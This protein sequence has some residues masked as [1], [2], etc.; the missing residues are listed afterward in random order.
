[1]FLTMPGYNNLWIAWN[2]QYIKLFNVRS[3]WDTHT[4]NTDINSDKYY[5]L[6]QLYKIN[7]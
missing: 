7:V 4:K 6:L 3:N 2:C 1:M 5:I